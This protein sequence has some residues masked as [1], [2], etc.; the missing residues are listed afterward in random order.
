MKESAKEPTSLLHD[1]IAQQHANVF[2]RAF[3]FAATQLPQMSDKPVEIADRVLLIDDSG[4]IFHLREREQKVAAKS[5]DIERW[6]AGQVV[7]KGVRRIQSTRDLL[8][9]YVGLSVVNHF[10]HR[11]TVTAKN[12]DALVGIMIYRVPPKTRPFRAARFKQNRNGGFVHILRDTDYFEICHHFVTP[13]ELLDYFNFRR[14]VLVSWDPPSTAVS[15]A[16]LIGQYLLEDFSSPPSSSLERAARSRGG[17]TACEFS[18]VLDTLGAEIA[19]IEHDESDDEH[20]DEE[21]GPTSD[22]R[23][24]IL[25]ELAL[26]GRYELRALKQQ[27]RQALEAVRANRFELPFRIA[28]ARTGCGFLIVPVMREFQERAFDALESLAMASKH[29]L[30]L[31]R[32]VGIGMWKNTEF[33]DIEWVLLKGKNGPF[34]QLDERLAHNYPFR[35]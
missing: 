19:A 8:A 4:F 34:P 33:V 21:N 22:D 31:E 28:S 15:E 14:D 1:F 11:M 16:A 6:V 25:S 9:G 17:P 10:G 7:K 27:L 18:F 3:S 29:E 26:L 20:D 5:A 12:P 32:Q 23:Y 35:R 2:M 13:A 30:D 24:E